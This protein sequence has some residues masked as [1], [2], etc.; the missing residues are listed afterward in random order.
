MTKEEARVELKKSF[1]DDEI[2]SILKKCCDNEC[3][4][5]CIKK[6]IDKKK[7]VKK[8]S[9]QKENIDIGDR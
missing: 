6:V 9:K 4:E 2:T 1:S 3:D 5:N 8:K 7:I